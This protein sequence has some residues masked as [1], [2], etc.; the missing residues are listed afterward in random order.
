MT[1][2][3]PL[4][5]RR[6]LAALAPLASVSP[7][8][9]PLAAHAQTAPQPALD[10]VVVTASRTP[11][12]VSSVLADLSVVDRDEIVRSGATNVADVLARLPGFEASRNGGPGSTTSVFLRGGE[13]RHTA[14]YIDGVRVDSQSTGGATWEQI[15]VDQIERIEVVRGP[16]AAVYG[17]D[18]VAGVVQLFTR[19]GRGPAQPSASVTLGA[20]GTAQVQAGVSG[21][22]G[23]L[24][25]SLSASHGRS[26]GFDAKTADATGH[27]PDRDGWTRSSLQGR[28]GYQ[29]ND[30]H[31]VDATLLASRLVSGYDSGTSSADD[32]N[33]HSL[34]SGSLAWQG[35]WNA[36]ATTRLRLGETRS[37][38]E[39]RP[40]FYGTRTTLRNITLQH[41]QRLGDQR[42]NLILERRE[43]RL[44]N[45]ATDYAAALRGHRHQDGIAL[46]WRGD[47]GAHALQAQLR[48]DQDSEFGGQN[49]GSLAWGWAFQPNWRV[50][51]SAATSFRAPTLYQRFSQYGNA[52]LV[53][54]TGRNLEAGL[55][56]SDAGSGASLTAWRNAVSNLISFG[57]PGPCADDYGCY[58]NAGRAVLRGV[59]LAGNTRIGP[60][61]LRG[62]IDW[63]DP[64]NTVTDTV[65]PRRA[66]RLATLG[67]DTQLAGWQL[68]AEV[69]AA[70]LRYDDAANTRRLGGY[71]L[72]N[73]T[74]RRALTPQL[75]LLLRVDNLA[76]K[77]YA[78]ARTYAT[79][80]RSVQASLRWAPK[81]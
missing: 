69:Q 35:R 12:A 27:N 54:E 57:D 46:G 44:D 36:D 4:R 21:S 53:P 23:A 51:A 80:R 58:V 56:W 77:N 33:R 3:S 20:Y 63:H 30:Q 62:S 9:I 79:A 43:D 61:A 48:H 37:R 40:D 31:R 49:T 24:D 81:T 18:A 13:T 55:R 39:T 6:L 70:G 65:L 71:A 59:N 42:V 75:E 67:A 47:F 10:A 76:D 34:I 1:L 17:S 64:R 66:R 11:Q 14:V 7:L 60:V 52:A 25:Y 74:A 22:S 19:R 78:V 73:L 28:L 26:D 29:I 68:G 5:A 15:P 2:R 45:P 72:V 50:T 41:E 32:E 8:L 16:V 38:Y